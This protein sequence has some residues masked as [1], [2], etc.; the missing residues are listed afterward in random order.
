MDMLKTLETFIRFSLQS[1][2]AQVDLIDALGP[3]RDRSQF[4]KKVRQMALYLQRITQETQDGIIEAIEE[5]SED[6]IGQTADIKNLFAQITR[7]VV[8]DESHEQ[9]LAIQKLTAKSH[10]MTVKV[11]GKKE[12][13]TEREILETFRRMGGAIEKLL[14]KIDRLRP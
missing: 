6:A 9:L 12:A 3:H 8:D 13:D 2:E 7:E 14:T 11:I 1:L 10:E 5:I 4:I